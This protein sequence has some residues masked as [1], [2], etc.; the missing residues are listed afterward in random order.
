MSAVLGL[1]VWLLLFVVALCAATVVHAATFTVDSTGDASDA[2]P[3]NG[4]CATAGAV[5]TLRAA[6]QEVNAGTGGDTIAFGIAGAGPHTITLGS[7]L[8]TITKNN[9]TIDA[10][11][12]SNAA[13]CCTGT[14]CSS[15][16]WKIKVDLNGGDFNGI[17]T[18]V[19]TTGFVIK[20][21]E[22]ANNLTT[23]EY[24]ITMDSGTATCNYVHGNRGGIAIGGPSGTIGGSG[25]NDANLIHNCD[26][27]GAT[28]RATT[29]STIRG[30]VLCVS[31]D[32]ESSGGSQNYGVYVEGATNTTVQGNLI[33]GCA[34][35]G[36]YTTPGASGTTITGNTIGPTRSGATALCFQFDAY[37]DDAPDT[38]FVSNT[39]CPT[40]GCC[41]VTG[42]EGFGTTCVDSTLGEGAPYSLANCNAIVNPVGGTA[43]DF[44]PSAMCDPGLGGTCPGVATATPT[45][46]ATATATNTHTAI[47]TSTATGTATPTAT[48]TMT[49]ATPVGTWAA[50]RITPVWSAP[51]LTPVWGVPTITPVWRA[52]P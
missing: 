32:G 44:N 38:S 5:C 16:S 15:A 4:T 24:G 7:V 25:T 14:N 3:G 22:I 6:I 9:I 35:A 48:P 52:T 51:T 12:G 43:S 1:L 42:L 37:Q 27:F 33:A 50:P 18:A 10:T 28:S 40:T 45:L 39:L 21:L 36:I 49:A 46:T 23:S 30:N 41:N 29:S 20:G 13:T 11:T 26:E 2:N 8:P 17:E 34:Q 19:G 31:A 47:P